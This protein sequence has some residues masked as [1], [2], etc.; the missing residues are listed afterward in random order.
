MS[1]E[2]KVL[3]IVHPGSACGSADFNLGKTARTVRAALADEITRWTGDF[4]VIDGDLSDE[5]P[6]Y[7][8][9]RTL[10]RALAD[11]ERDGRHA[12][13]TYACALQAGWPDKAADEFFKIWDPK[14]T[15][16]LITGAWY[17]DDGHG[18][19]N[20]VQRTL[21]GAASATISERALRL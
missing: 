8:I 3:V 9:G 6:H 4:L 1:N 12:H 5:L 15:K 14:V 21:G 2:K 19:I 13:R 18:C 20:A 16:V 10:V 17:Q 7:D 11:A